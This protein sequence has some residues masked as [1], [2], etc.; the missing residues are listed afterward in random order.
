M[1]GILGKP[2][3]NHVQLTLDRARRPD[4]RHGGWRPNAGRARLPGAVSHDARPALKSRFPQL[5]TLRLVPD[6]GSIARDFLMSTIRRCI[7]AANR[8][9]FRIVEFNVLSNHLH[10]ITE[11]NDKESLARGVQGF[12]VRIARSLNSALKRTGKLF[13]QRYHAR[14][15]TTPTQVRY[16]LRYVLLNRKHHAAEKEFSKTWFDPWSSAAWFDGWTTPLR[17]SAGWQAELLAME[18]PT[19]RPQ[20]WLLSTGWKIKGLLR[21]DD[22]PR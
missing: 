15:L 5:V 20:T 2:R 9:T 21:L 4:G 7:R 8:S 17:A 1:S 11:A 6:V 10:L 16:A 3:K 18:R 19:A 14:Q 22:R 13:A 12:S